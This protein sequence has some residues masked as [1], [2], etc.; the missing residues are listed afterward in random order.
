MLNVKFQSITVIIADA[1]RMYNL[2]LNRIGI[3]SDF[4]K[5]ILRFSF[6]SLIKSKSELKSRIASIKPVKL[7]QN[8]SAIA[9]FLWFSS[10][11]DLDFGYDSFS[12]RGYNLSG[13]V[14]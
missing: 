7:T 9:L 10:E 11:T 14:L 4:L 8:F 1:S 5:F 6:L 2:V 3:F 12:F 13:C